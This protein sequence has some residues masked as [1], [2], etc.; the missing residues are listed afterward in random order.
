M[1]ERV[2]DSAFVQGE[3]SI[4]KFWNRN[5]IFDKLRQQNRGKPKWS[6]MD[7]PITANNPMGVHHAWGRTY[8][9]VYQR[10]RAMTG[11]ELR[12]Q[13]G[14]DC[15]G[16]WVEVEV[17]KQL[18][19]GE[20][21]RIEDFGIDQ[22]SNECK[23][24]V[25]RYAARQTEQ[26]QRLGYWMDWDLPDELRKL[27]D[28]LGTDESVSLQTPTGLQETGAAHELIARLGNEKWGGSYF[29]FSTQNNETIWSFLKKCHQRGKIYRG[30]DVMPWS[31]RAGCAYSQMEVAD[32]RRLTVHKSVFVRFP[33]KERPNEYLLVW[34]TTPWT[35]TS[36]VGV[37]VNS[38]LKY[39]KLRA[40]RDGAIYYFAQE[41]LEFARLQTE[42]KQ[43]F[44]R[45]EWAWPA[46][47]G[48]LK[49][50]AQI[51]KEQGGYEIEGTILGK[52]MIGW[53]YVGPFDDLPA[54]QQVGGFPSGIMRGP[55]GERS[56]VD[57]HRVVDGGRDS[58]GN[59]NVVAGEGT[60][61]VH[62]A[63]GCGDVDFHLG[64][65]EGLVPIAPLAADSR[66]LPGFGSFTGLNAT[67]K[68]T[69]EK[70]FEELRSKHL[71]VAVEDYPHIY[72]HC[73]RTGDE[74]VFRL[75]DEW[76][77][78]MDWR[79]EIKDVV[80]KIR[81]LPANMDGQQRELEWLSNM[82][83]WMISKKRFWG[84]AL[85]IWF[86]EY[87]EAGQLKYD[88]EVFGSL[89]ELK[90]R[91]V[92]GW[93]EFSNNSPH[94][95]WIDRIKIRNPKTGRLMAR[96]PDV[97]NPWL[98]AGIV[99]FS[100]LQYM[101]DRE[102][103][104]EWYPADFVTECFPGQFRN[105]FYALLS[106]ATMMDNSPPFKTLLGHRLVMDEK[107]RPMHKSD[108]T[109]IWF[110]E[111]AEQLGVDTVRWMFLAQSP[112]TDLRFGSRAKDKPVT[113][114]T[115]DGPMDKTKEGEPI[116]L[117]TSQ[118][119]DDIRRQ[120]LIPLWNSY[121]FFVN[122]S[123]ADGFDPSIEQVPLAERP[124]IDRWILSHLQDLIATCNSRLEDFHA[125]EMCAACAEFIDDLSNWY[126]R[127]NRR[128]FW[129]SRDASDRDKL[130]AYQTLYS[131]LTTL[132]KLLAP[133]IPFLTERM[134]QNLV[135]SF[136]T[137]NELPES[138]HL[139]AYPSVQ[140][141]W[142]D[143][144]L[145]E[146]ML[147]AQ[148]VVRMGHKL[149]DEA[150]LRVRQPLAEIRCAIVGDAAADGQAQAAVQSLSDV[151]LDEL[152][153]KRLTTAQSLSELVSYNYKPNLKSLGQKYGKLSNA[154]REYLQNAAQS[155]LAPLRTGGQLSI[156]VGGQKVELSSEDV[157]VEIVNTTGWVFSEERGLQVAIS[158][159]VTPEL[160][161]EG[162][163]RDFVRQVQ[164]LRKDA[165]L[166]IEDRIDVHYS[167]ATDEIVQAIEE[168]KEY[169]STETLANK[170][171]RETDGT[172][173]DA[174]SVHIGDI[175]I[176]VR[177]V[178]A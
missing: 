152:N 74:L 169:I 96:V 146:R 156:D 115:V 26:S 28:K 69:A 46:G 55:Q 110:E 178:K 177:I 123:I 20:K 106:M 86:E 140:P 65:A 176:A 117:V 143:P 38:E 92:E 133:C 124:E 155:E 111:A 81:W 118:P 78:R 64:H 27:A 72:P 58:K 122:Y 90:E 63:P 164:Q 12:Y 56:A 34:T 35:L 153:I 161:R 13:N 44:G 129:R 61:I 5:C 73:W 130:A 151:I 132:T 43:G 138:V 82:S 170:V 89:A 68:S 37:A 76:F 121:A 31:G 41:N 127:R 7:G 114:Q 159:V 112:G 9:D 175:E 54:Q 17:E 80:R 120:I 150:N 6:F 126:I 15:Q 71:L 77:I 42:F 87:E 172:S 22:F 101:T 119:A 62:I 49:S 147:L 39:V 145:N 95:P 91:A 105:W 70:V 57:C 125:A 19:L 14:F 171:L 66:F 100:T 116:C 93:E 79:D 18:G 1:F 154:I 36:N 98:D 60:G 109:A 45:P 103:W 162:I 102:A 88:F 30:F 94:R 75:V 113:V 135:R 3:H 29:T 137:G 167:R 108:G 128:R 157:L 24:R 136:S 32:G 67:E 166:Q 142:L 4:L 131:V 149:R 53:K 160:R 97:G 83:D 104:K 163:S 139:C 21:N 52:E 16:L 40:K 99:P 51:F 50:I 168:W 141:E 10:F 33:L 8:K 48:K 148:R 59:P 174:K 134:Y 11:H 144:L 107:G 173:S 158:T 47:V 23:R 84:L 25:L 85:P 165:D 2:G